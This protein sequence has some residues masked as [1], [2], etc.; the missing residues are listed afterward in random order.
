[1]NI[2]GLDE[3]LKRVLAGLNEITSDPNNIWHLK[4]GRKYYKLNCGTSGAVLVEK[5]SGELFNIKAYGVADRNKKRK[6][7]IGNIL[8][9]DPAE[10]HSRRWNYHR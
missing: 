10:L 7:D 8:T 6:A 9:C 1:M 2:N 3:A 4:P 5:D